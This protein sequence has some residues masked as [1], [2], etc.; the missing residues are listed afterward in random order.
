VFDGN[1]V[2]HI[3]LR[4]VDEPRG[5]VIGCTMVERDT[6]SGLSVIN[7]I[8]AGAPFSGFSTRGHECGKHE[9]QTLF[10]NNTAHSV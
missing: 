5:G 8:V 10:K 1:V 4:I 3:L 7:N 6:C 2:G 9:E